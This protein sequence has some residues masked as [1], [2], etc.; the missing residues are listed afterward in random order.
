MMDG[1][2]FRDRQ[3]KPISD[4]IAWAKLVEDDEYRIVA[5]DGNPDTKYAVSTIWTGITSPVGALFE[6]ALLDDKGGVVE[7]DRW[8]T[9]EGA[10]EGHAE[11][12]RKHFGRDP[13][14]EDGH[15]EFVILRNSALSDKEYRREGP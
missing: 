1:A 8:Y 9:E 10:I 6:T 5:I 3:G 2:M 14:P 7:M 12:C 11:M 4:A 15:R 13:R